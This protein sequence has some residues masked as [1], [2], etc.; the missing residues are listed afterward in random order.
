VRLLPGRWLKVTTGKI[1]KRKYQSYQWGAVIDLST[2]SLDN[3]IRIFASEPETHADTLEG[4]GPARY[5]VIPKLGSIV[6][7]CYKRGGVISRINKQYYLKTGAV[8]SKKEFEFLLAAAKSGASVSKPIAYASLGGIFYKAWLITEVI[9]D[10]IS[11]ARLSRDKKEKA[12]TLMPSIA[13]NIRR[14]IQN[15]IHHVDLHPGNILI[16]KYDRNYI[17]DFDKAYYFSGS[18]DKLTGLYQKRWNKAVHKHRLPE[19]LTSL[20][21]FQ[22]TP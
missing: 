9:E 11:F 19:V 18:R 4:R 2:G 6:V 5:A 16:D 12:V 20:P 21:L 13:R 8:R 3:L 10:H 22:R 7:K 17:I 1:Y 15:K 14:L